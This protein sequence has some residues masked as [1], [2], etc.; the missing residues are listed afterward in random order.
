MRRS[1]PLRVAVMTTMLAASL[2]HPRAAGAVSLCFSGDDCADGKF[3]TDNFCIVGVCANPARNCDDGDS[4]T[5]DSCS[6]TQNTCRHIQKAEGAACDDG[7]IFTFGETCTAD[8]RC[9]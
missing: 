8:G 1:T 3:C 6:E 7:N 9:E 4:C 5:T 2:I